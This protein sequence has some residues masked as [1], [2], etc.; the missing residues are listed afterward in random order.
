MNGKI[1]RTTQR[2]RMGIEIAGVAVV[3]YKSEGGRK[4]S[5]IKA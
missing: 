1:R 4:I 2:M 5:K 3:G